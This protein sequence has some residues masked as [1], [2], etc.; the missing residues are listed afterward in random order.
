MP[1]ASGSRC[2][3]L[4][5]PGTKFPD[6]RPAPSR[7]CR[8]SPVSE[9]CIPSRNVWSH[10]NAG[11]NGVT[12]Q[13]GPS[14]P[15]A[16]GHKMQRFQRNWLDKQFHNYLLGWQSC[17]FVLICLNNT[18]RRLLRP[19]KSI[20]NFAFDYLLATGS[21]GSTRYDIQIKSI[22]N[23]LFKTGTIG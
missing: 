11:G 7:R 20:H 13:N 10:Q 8:Y 1:A 14:Q 21:L 23:S 15:Q 4:V 9:I 22:V 12:R 2:A 18:R 16:P 17:F 3:G 6:L 19:C 5:Q